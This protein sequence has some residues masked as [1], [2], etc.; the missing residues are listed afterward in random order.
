VKQTSKRR[1]GLRL[2]SP[3]MTVACIALAIALS[4]VSYAAVVL[5]RNS[6][7]TAQLKNNAVKSSKVAANTLNGGDINEARLGQVPSALNAQNAASAMNAQSAANAGRLDDLDST[8]FLRANGKAADANALD[9]FDSLTFVKAGDVA[10]GDLSGSFPNPVVG[11]DAISGNEIANGSLTAQDV[12]YRTGASAQ[13]FPSVAAGDCY[14]NQFA[15]G[16]DVNDIVLVSASVALGDL[17][18]TASERATIGAGS[19]VFRLKLCNPTASAIDPPL[20]TY[21]YIIINV[22]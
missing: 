18:L 2:P 13:D 14:I 1:R 3:A 17:I 9:G 22:P 8:D 4:G 21:S 15:A 6:V 11:P 7:G 5:P 16:G 10:G 12:G 20:A 19:A